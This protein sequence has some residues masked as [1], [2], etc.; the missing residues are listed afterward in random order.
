M[1]VSP[2]A[3]PTP[4]FLD[5][6]ER[7]TMRTPEAAEFLG[8]KSTTLEHLRLRGD[9]PRFYKVGKLV[10]YAKADLDAWLKSRAV[11]SIAET[12]ARGI[13]RPPTAAQATSKS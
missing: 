12:Y 2:P 4:K 8:L 7:P 11:D 6:D 13:S 3:T 10:R 5:D 1:K 9:G